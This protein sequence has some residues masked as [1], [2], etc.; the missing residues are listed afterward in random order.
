MICYSCFT[1]LQQVI[2]V[3]DVVTHFFLVIW[4]VSIAD[5]A[6]APRIGLFTE[7]GG[8][9]LYAVFLCTVSLSLIASDVPCWNF[10]R[11]FGPLDWDPSS[12]FFERY[13]NTC[14]QYE[15]L[16]A[17]SHGEYESEQQNLLTIYIKY[18]TKYGETNSP[19]AA[20]ESSIKA[21]PTYDEEAAEEVYDLRPG[22]ELPSNKS[23]IGLPDNWRVKNRKRSSTVRTSSR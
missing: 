7:V 15:Y 2:L 5:I 9:F 10:I 18:P 19:R 22:R 14:S 12:F 23:V 4:L 11:A 20:H 21:L 13:F 6:S 3:E 8:V 17:R 16:N 1:L